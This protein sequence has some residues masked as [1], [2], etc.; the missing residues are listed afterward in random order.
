MKRLIHTILLT[1]WLVPGMLFCQQKT[2][3]DFYRMLDK[4]YKKTVPLV[5]ADQVKQKGLHQYVILDTREPEEYKVSH[6][7]G[8]VDAGYDHFDPKVVSGIAKDKP[9]LVYC[10]VGY[11]SERIGEKLKSMGYTQ[12]YNLY[13]GI[14]DWKNH[15]N[16]VVDLSGSNTEKVHT[17]NFQWS[18]WLLKGEKVY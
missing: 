11:R 6:L 10:S 7:P 8:A 17:Y 13:G 12:V 15:G 2:E 3:P 14:F 16:T 9:I 4:M 5:H 1:A 18:Q